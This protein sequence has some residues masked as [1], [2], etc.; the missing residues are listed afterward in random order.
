MVRRR[1]PPLQTWKTFLRN[2]ADVIAGIDMCVVPTVT[3]DL[4][5]F[6]NFV[7]SNFNDLQSIAA[8]ACNKNATNQCS[9]RSLGSPITGLPDTP[10]LSWT[11]TPLTHQRSSFDAALELLLAEIAETADYREPMSGDEASAELT[12]L[13]RKYNLTADDP[14]HIEIQINA[15]KRVDEAVRRARFTSGSG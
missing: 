9:R 6:S 1:K 10:P 14:D 7:T 2:H 3:F 5:N 12:N 11:E 4:C 13:F 8:G 15:R